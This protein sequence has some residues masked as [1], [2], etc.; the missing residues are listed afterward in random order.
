MVF[1]FLR[2]PDGLAKLVGLLCSPSLSGAPVLV[3]CF[4]VYETS[5]LHSASPA[6]ARYTLPTC[7]HT[8]IYNLSFVGLDQEMAS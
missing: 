7:N 1:E 4:C 8:A 3:A 5:V 2:I 6:G